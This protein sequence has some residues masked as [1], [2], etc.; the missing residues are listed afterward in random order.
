MQTALNRLPWGYSQP[1]LRW[2]AC[3]IVAVEA[4]SYVL[5]SGWI[6]GAFEPVRIEHDIIIV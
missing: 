4:P 5:L 1:W 6:S 3:R 2:L